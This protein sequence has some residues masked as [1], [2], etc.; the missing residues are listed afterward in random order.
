[1]S[2][3]SGKNMYAQVVNQQV[4]P[5]ASKMY[6]SW[7]NLG[8]ATLSSQREENATNNPAWAIG[9]YTR[10]KKGKGYEYTTPW[11]ITAHSFGLDIPSDAVVNK[12]VVEARMKVESGLVVTAPLA[13]FMVYGGKGSVT[14][15]KNIDKSG[16]V[17]NQYLVVKNTKLSTTAQTIAYEFPASEL[18]DLKELGTHGTD[19]VIFLEPV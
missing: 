12:V 15:Q 7:K 16:W 11:V 1:M 14:S 6:N 4:N 5:N 3:A 8:N 10:M 2:T 19:A 17:G 9:Y 13:H 18:K